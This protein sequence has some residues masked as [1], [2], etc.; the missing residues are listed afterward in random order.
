MEHSFRFYN[1]GKTQKEPIGY[2]LQQSL[3]ALTW[4]AKGDVSKVEVVVEV[5]ERHRA[6]FLVPQRVAVKQEFVVGSGLDQ[7]SPQRSGVADL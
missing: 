5:E 7:P 4:C 6:S 1:F 3:K 2:F